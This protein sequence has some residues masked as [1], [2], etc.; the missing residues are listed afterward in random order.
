MN[1]RINILG[2][3]NFLDGIASN[4]PINDIKVGLK[5]GYKI[6]EINIYKKESI[7][8]IMEYF[9]ENSSFFLQ[10][11]YDKFLLVQDYMNKSSYNYK[12]S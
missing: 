2:T 1:P 9:Y 6:Y 5:S 4:L 10:R 8:K 12:H 7:L 3:K 11:K